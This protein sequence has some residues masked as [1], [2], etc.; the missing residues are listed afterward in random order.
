MEDNVRLEGPVE[1]ARIELLDVDCLG[2]YQVGREAALGFFSEDA[3]TLPLEA[4]F[5]SEKR[6]R[7][8][9]SHNVE[10]SKNIIEG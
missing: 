3:S 1:G 7:E 4:L 10:S 6:Y 8:D 5:L 2:E 9:S